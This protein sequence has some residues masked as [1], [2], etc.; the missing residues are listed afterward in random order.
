M[1]STVITTKGT[2][3]I[4]KEVRDYLNLVPG[5]RL[6]FAINRS[7]V[8]IEKALSLEEVRLQNRTYIQKSAPGVSLQDAKMRASNARLAEIEKK[9]KK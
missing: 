8:V 2:T 5:S 3:T 6:T 9:Y 1:K 7:G 4:P